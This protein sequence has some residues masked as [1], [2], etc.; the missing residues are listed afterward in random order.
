MSPVPA[1]ERGGRE[2]LTGTVPTRSRLHAARGGLTRFVGRDRELEQLAQAQRAAAG[3]GQAVAVVGEAGVGKSR[4]TWEFTRSHRTQG[5]LVLES[6]SV[7]YGRPRRTCP[8][9][10]Y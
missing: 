1:Q 9:S 2:V 5:W 10:S 6:G 7:S 3:H 8:S 4:L